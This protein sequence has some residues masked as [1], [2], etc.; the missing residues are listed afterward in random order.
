[1]SSIKSWWDVSALYYR[2]LDN[3]AQ[4]V[5]FEE[6]IEELELE[7]ELEPELKLDDLGCGIGSLLQ[8][9]PEGVQIRGIDQSQKAIEQAQGVR[10]D[11]K[12]IHA[13]FYEGLPNGYKP[14][15]IVASRSLYHPD[16]NLS[17]GL[18]SS[19]LADSGIAIVTLPVP[20]IMKYIMPQGKIDLVHLLK[21][22]GRIH[23][24]F[25]DYDY[26]LF[27]AEELEEAGKQHFA[28]VSV[29]EAGLGTHYLM[30]LEK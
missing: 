12:F 3:E 1:M 22:T 16:L 15:R 25:L 19:H 13:D 24:K 29:Q 30:K 27:A 6:I 9:V 18:V 28:N 11:S 10:P 26:A 17:L 21:A 2:F 8:L 4:R 23:S 5:M 14:D 20:D 7:L